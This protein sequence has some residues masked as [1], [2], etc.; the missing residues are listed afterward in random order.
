MLSSEGC[1]I[2]ESVREVIVNSF[3][4]L[5]YSEHNLLLCRCFNGHLWFTTK[6]SP[7]NLKASRSLREFVWPMD[8]KQSVHPR[9]FRW[10]LDKDITSFCIHSTQLLTA[11][12]FTYWMPYAFISRKRFSFTII[13]S[14]S[15]L[16]IGV[17]IWVRCWNFQIWI[18][19]RSLYS[20]INNSGIS[21]LNGMLDISSLCISMPCSSI[22]IFVVTSGTCT[23][24]KRLGH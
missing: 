16:H 9:V 5:K 20:F 14:V 23:S 4:Y 15:L 2:W 1:W 22:V 3:E 6:V 17:D 18:I 11:M 19:C 7:Q 21:F 13:S 12:R 10:W 24:I 8:S